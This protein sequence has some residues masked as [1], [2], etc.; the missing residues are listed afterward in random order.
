MSVARS[1]DNLIIPMLICSS[2]VIT[3]GLS[4]HGSCSTPCVADCGILG[5]ALK[6]LYQQLATNTPVSLCCLEVVGDSIRDLLLTARPVDPVERPKCPSRRR[7]T[8]PA[9]VSRGPP[10]MR[11]VR[12]TSNHSCSSVVV[13]SAAHALSILKP[14]LARRTTLRSG[15]TR[16]STAHV[17][18]Q[19]AWTTG[20]ASSTVPP[21]RTPAVVARASLDTSTR[22]LQSKDSSGISARSCRNKGLDQVQVVPAP[23]VGAAGCVGLVLLDLGQPC[24][25]TQRTVPLANLRGLQCLGSVLVSIAHCGQPGGALQDSRLTQVM[26]PALHQVLLVACMGQAGA[27]DV[28]FCSVGCHP[29]DRQA[30]SPE[31]WGDV[32]PTRLLMQQLAAAAQMSASELCSGSSSKAGW[33]GAMPSGP[34]GADSSSALRAAASGSLP[35][36]TPQ[37]QQAALGSHCS[38]PPP[39]L[40][41]GA[42]PS[43][44]PKSCSRNPAASSRPPI[45]PG[46]AKPGLEARYQ[47]LMQDFQAFVG[48]R[49]RC[50]SADRVRQRSQ[51]TLP[52][53][54][55]AHRPTHSLDLTASAGNAP[56]LMDG[57]ELEH[58]TPPCS[59]EPHS[60]GYTASSPPAASASTTWLPSSRHSGNPPPTVPS[61][62]LPASRQG[63]PAKQVLRHQVLVPGAAAD[64]QG[65]EEMDPFTPGSLQ[66][67]DGVQAPASTGS[68]LSPRLG[69]DLVAAILAGK[70]PPSHRTVQS[71]PLSCARAAARRSPATA[72][73]YVSQRST[74]H[75]PRDRPCVAAHGQPASG[76]TPV[77]L[78]QQRSSRY[79]SRFGSPS[80]VHAAV[81]PA[82]NPTPSAKHVTGIQPTPAARSP[83][84]AAS[85]PGLAAK[86]R[87]LA[88]STSSTSKRPVAM[89]HSAASRLA[90]GSS[91][92]SSVV[93]T[94]KLPGHP[95]LNSGRGAVGRAMTSPGPPGLA[96]AA[97]RT[98]LPLPVPVRTRSPVRP[99]HQERSSGE[100]EQRQWLPGAAGAQ[101]NTADAGRARATG[102]AARPRRA[103][104][105]PSLLQPQ[106]PENAPLPPAMLWWSSGQLAHASKSQEASLPKAKPPHRPCTD[107]TH[108]AGVP[109]AV[110]AVSTGSSLLLGAS[111]ASWSNRA[112]ELQ[113]PSLSSSTVPSQP[114]S[115]VPLPTLMEVPSQP[116]R[117]APAHLR[118]PPV[119]GAGPLLAASRQRSSHA[120]S[121]TSDSSQEACGSPITASL[122]ATPSPVAVL[123]LLDISQPASTSAGPSPSV[124][125]LLGE[126]DTPLSQLAQRAASIDGRVRRGVSR[127]A[128]LPPQRSPSGSATPLLQLVLP[129]RLGAGQAGS[130]CPSP[131]PTRSPLSS[132]HPDISPH[133]TAP[134]PLQPCNSWG[135]AHTSRHFLHQPSDVTAAQELS[136]TTA[137]LA[138]ALDEDA[139]VQV[140]ELEASPTS[141]RSASP[142]P[143]QP[144]GPQ[145]SPSHRLSH[146]TPPACVGSGAGAGVKGP[147]SRG[148]QPGEGGVAQ[149]GAA[150]AGLVAPELQASPKRG[151]LHMVLS[152]GKGAVAS[153]F[154]NMR[155]R[156]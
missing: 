63:L 99:S 88:G 100:E 60:L 124:S 92:S 109:S 2:S 69:L 58:L 104:T 121:R 22:L 80:T 74:M 113:W 117:C 139:D 34:E 87:W 71:T 44:P 96:A 72:P 145:P 10:S 37:A 42:L 138:A 125:A 77:T 156:L 105:A 127:A 47:S 61:P 4:G 3:C 93:S 120:S 17:I 56:A 67:A 36:R 38:A 94:S 75:A 118:P 57:V 153:M 108:A 39:Q 23:A 137:D 73:T 16:C 149:L 8:V 115:L 142:P 12:V 24:P 152:S 106:W 66:P 33:S 135:S 86:P 45:P 123:A 30:E 150:H 116:A 130:P 141:S 5:R 68:L 70:S 101:Q 89:H 111:Q 146:S 95:A 19:L 134:A 112:S 147:G 43:Q 83:A 148:V 15:L 110:T 62:A 126:A 11:S 103:P 129:S 32:P 48:S 40:V 53:P 59:P 97:K 28:P 81:G 82:P 122:A 20:T 91:V 79:Q 151:A 140:M 18:V 90:A 49:R 143:C 102:F 84:H 155:K 78:L 7:V 85:P 107:D 9:M 114:C 76:S 154:D 144:S 51:H 52:S 133:S 128:L 132:Q 98:Q 54:C 21:P 1:D 29:A 27:R 35:A 119:A 14:A 55:P 26:A 131:R 50:S 6:L 136:P 13:V 41:A 65:E 64:G 25:T 31:P 46:A